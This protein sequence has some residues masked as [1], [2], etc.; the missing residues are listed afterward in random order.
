MLTNEVGAGILIAKLISVSTGIS[1]GVSV[2]LGVS[3]GF[4]IGFI[5]GLLASTG[6]EP[7]LILIK[8]G[9]GYGLGISHVNYTGVFKGSVRIPMGSWLTVLSVKALIGF[10][11]CLTSCFSE[12][13]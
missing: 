11:A 13:N 2:F 8:L 5:T 10:T 4:G 6:G 7:V 3:L 9:W 1:T 12:F